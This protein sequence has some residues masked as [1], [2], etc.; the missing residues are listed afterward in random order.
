MSLEE[1]RS[2]RNF[3]ETPEPA[4]RVRRANRTHIF[5]V[6]KHAARR[7]NFYRLITQRPDGD[8]GMRV[9]HAGTSRCACFSPARLG[10]AARGSALGSFQYS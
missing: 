10:R 6:Q 4:G 1:Y 7:K 5:V 8:G 2:K 9:F 3:T